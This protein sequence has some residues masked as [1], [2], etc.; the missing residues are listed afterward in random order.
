MLGSFMKTS[1]Q[2]RWRLLYLHG[3]TQHRKTRKNIRAL[4]EIRNHDLSV[5]A[6]KAYVSDRTASGTGI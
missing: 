3:A 2:K 1:G 5:Q 6:I 4:S